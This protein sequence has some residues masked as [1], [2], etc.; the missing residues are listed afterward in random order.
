MMGT[1]SPL[2]A[3]PFLHKDVNYDAIKDFTPVTRVGSFTLM[4][5]VNPKLPIHSVKELVDYAKANPGKLTFASGNTAGIVGRRDAQ[6]LG[7]D[8]HPARALQEHAAG[9]RG[10]HRRPRLDDVRRF[11]HRHAARRGRHAAGARG[12]AHQAQLAVPGSADR[13]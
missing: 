13:G 5:V 6:A 2:S 11:H 9:D 7:R 8:R 12:L 4:L 10:H 3:D 1:N